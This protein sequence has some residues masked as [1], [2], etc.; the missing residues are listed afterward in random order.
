MEATP[1]KLIAV[2]VCMN[3]NIQVTKRNVSPAAKASKTALELRSFG[4]K[5]NNLD[6]FMTI[7]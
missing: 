4:M 1:S 6:L 5:F 7:G 3:S 2:L